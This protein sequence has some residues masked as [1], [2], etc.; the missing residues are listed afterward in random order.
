MHQLDLKPQA[1]ADWIGEWTDGIVKEILQC[2]ADLPSWD[3]ETD[4]QVQEYVNGL[5]YWVRG[6]DDWSF[7]SQRYFVVDG[8][9][10][11]GEREIWMIPRVEV[12]EARRTVLGE[13]VG[14]VEGRGVAGM[15]ISTYRRRGWGGQSWRVWTREDMARGRGGGEEL[16][17]AALGGGN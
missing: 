12:Q 14:D 15:Q 17:H 13:G 3:P 9:R 8:E 5:A 2:R 16:G 7:E 4:R 10:V 11:R 6:N 1:A